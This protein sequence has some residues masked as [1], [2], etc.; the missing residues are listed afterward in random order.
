[1]SIS[2]CP[3]VV[4][5]TKSAGDHRSLRMRRAGCPRTALLRSQPRYADARVSTA[6]GATIDQRGV[7]GGAS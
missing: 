2:A 3:L 1:M 5:K 7:I 4:V 6:A